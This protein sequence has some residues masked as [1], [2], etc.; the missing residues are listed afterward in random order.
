[1]CQEKKESEGS[2]AFG[3][4]GLLKSTSKQ[5]RLRQADASI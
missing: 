1:M 2:T 5:R 4:A 3:D